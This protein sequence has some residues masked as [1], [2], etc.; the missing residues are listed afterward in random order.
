MRKRSKHR[1]ETMAS[2]ITKSGAKMSLAPLDFDSAVRAAMATG[3]PPKAKPSKKPA[4]QVKERKDGVWEVIVSKPNS[5]PVH[6]G[7]FKTE[8]E[9]QAWAKARR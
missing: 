8:S 2:N 5:A 9:A 6:V 3:T 7:D 4:Y 1:L